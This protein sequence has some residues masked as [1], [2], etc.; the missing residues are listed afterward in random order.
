MS[1]RISQETA[2]FDHSSEYVYLISF[3]YGYDVNTLLG[4]IKVCNFAVN[5]SGNSKI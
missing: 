4:V 3:I 1:G 5:P 2:Y